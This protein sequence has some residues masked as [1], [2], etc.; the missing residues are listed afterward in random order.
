MR[1]SGKASRKAVRQTRSRNEERVCLR[2]DIAPARFTAQFSERTWCRHRLMHSSRRNICPG[3]RAQEEPLQQIRERGP[4]RRGSYRSERRAAGDGRPY[5]RHNHGR[6]PARDPIYLGWTPASKDDWWPCPLP[7]K[8]TLT[9][10]MNWTASAARNSDDI[11][12]VASESVTWY[13]FRVSVE[14]VAAP[15]LKLP[16]TRTPPTALWPSRNPRA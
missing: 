2:P 3:H 7:R 14:R 4:D 9:G 13:L 15:S 16:S 11:N 6:L 8:V 5:R 12:L 10:S 1:A